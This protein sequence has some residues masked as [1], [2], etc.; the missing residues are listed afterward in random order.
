MFGKNE[1]YIQ[2][3]RCW[4]QSSINSRTLLLFSLFFKGDIYFVFSSPKN[5]YLK[6]LEDIVQPVSTT[7]LNLS[8]RFRVLIIQNQ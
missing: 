2:F 1:Y 8:A 5:V 6:I 7:F 4:F 3:Y